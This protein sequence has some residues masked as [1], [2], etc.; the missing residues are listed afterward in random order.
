[1]GFSVLRAFSKAYG[2]GMSINYDYTRYRFN[3]SDVNELEQNMGYTQAVL[4]Y[5][6]KIHTRSLNLGEWTL[7]L[8]QRVRLVPGGLMGNGF[9][10][11]LGVYGSIGIDTYRLYGEHPNTPASSTDI[12]YYYPDPT[13]DYRWNYGITTRLTYD[14]I[15]I[16]ARYRLN[17]I[18]KDVDPGKVLLPRFTIGIQ[19]MY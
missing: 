5:Y 17:G 16:Y 15:G 1:M 3:D 2:I 18:G 9:H 7:E 19:L 13:K 12:S 6:K 14:W 8:F 10:W 11:D 4:D